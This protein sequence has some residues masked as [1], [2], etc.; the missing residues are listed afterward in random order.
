MFIS[1][2]LAD[3]RARIKQL[4]MLRRKNQILRRMLPDIILPA[5]AENVLIVVDGNH[6]RLRKLREYPLCLRVFRHFPLH[7]DMGKRRVIIRPV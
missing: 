4:T 3:L 5:P 6:F 1:K 7:I 2:A